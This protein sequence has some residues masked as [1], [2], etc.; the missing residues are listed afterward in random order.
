MCTGRSHGIPSGSV[1]NRRE[2]PEERAKQIPTG[3]KCGVRHIGLLITAGVVTV[4]SEMERR[5]TITAEIMSNFATQS[6]L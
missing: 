5:R 4:C 3:S 6:C 2:R 1:T